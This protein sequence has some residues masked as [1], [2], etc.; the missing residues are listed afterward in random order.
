MGPRARGVV[1]S[2]R[3]LIGTLLAIVGGLYL[4]A[5]GVLWAFQDRMVFPAPGGID[6]SSLDQAARELGAK[7]LRL[8]AS[9]GVSLYAWHR[10]AN[11]DRLV[12]YLPGNGETVSQNAA[13]HRLLLTEGWD[14][15]ALAYR[16]YPGSEGKPSEAGLALDA[17]AAWAWATGPGGFSPDRIVLHGRSLGGGVAA[18]LAEDRN[19][20][21]VVLESTFMS[22]RPLARRVAPWAP[23]DLILRHPFDTVERAPRLGVPVFVTHSVSDQVIPVEVGGRALLPFL[24]DATYVETEGVGHQQCLPVVDRRVRE[25]Y[26]R[27]LAENV[28]RT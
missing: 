27:F 19:P 24:A 23:V 13:L 25:A 22:T 4:G 28:P 5:V 15:M 3:V 10:S 21:A 14:V 1:L 9:D 18:H 20:A 26:I 12:I 6:P 17:Q 11:A 16:G 7:P 8:T 2:A